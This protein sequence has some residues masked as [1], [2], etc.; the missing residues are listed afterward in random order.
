MKTLTYFW[1]NVFTTEQDKG[2][3]LPVF[4]L[5]DPLNPSSMQ[6]IAAMMNQSE[7]I[8]IEHV[9]STEPELSIFTP[10]Q[11]L[12]FAGHPIIGALKILEKLQPNPTFDHVKTA[13]GNVPVEIDRHKHIYWIKA[14][15]APTM[16]PST[17]TT[18]AATAQML[19]LTE[20]N[21]LSLPVWVNTGN[22]QLLVELDSPEAVDAIM[23]NP[24]LF[25]EH[26]TLYEG[27]T[28]IYAWCRTD[29][30][31]YARYFYLKNGV[32]GEDSG[33]GSAAANLGGLQLLKGTQ[34]QPMRIRQGYKMGRENILYLKVVEDDIW[35]GGQNTFM[36]QGELLWAE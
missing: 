19:G 8:F 26:A 4:V 30:D 22:E 14:P 16:R 35:I 1:I 34:S 20:Q 3:P 29:N 23:I 5:D 7:T 10:M 12:P 27:R 6:K 2:N 17:L 11:A 32:I 36:G 13:S 28:M 31:V 21:I 33:T 9:D 15:L 25:A 24:A 18:T